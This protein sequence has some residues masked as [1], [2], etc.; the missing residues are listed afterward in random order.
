MQ[1][2]THGTFTFSD[3]LGDLAARQAHDVRQRDELALL[4][5]QPFERAFD[6]LDFFAHDQRTTGTRETVEAA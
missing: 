4:V 3:L 5:R 1:R 6:A 2:D